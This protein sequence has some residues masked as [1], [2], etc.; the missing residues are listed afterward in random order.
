MSA[1]ADQLR[2]HLAALH[3]AGV[4]FVPPAGPSPELA[5]FAPPPPPPPPPVDTT[6]VAL[7]TLAAEVKKCEKCRELFASRTQTV[8]GGGPVGAVVGFVSD[9]PHADDDRTGVLFA[10]AVG[11]LFDNMLTKGMDL[12]REE[13]YLCAV[14]K[15][16]PPKNRPPKADECN[17]CRGFLERQLALARPQFLCALGVSAAQTLLG[18]TQPLP[19]LRGVV[20]DLGGT[21]LVC[22]HHPAEVQ[23]NPKLKGPVWE[24]LKR[25]LK[26]MGRNPKGK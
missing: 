18:T 5:I 24:D 12:K 6:R 11:E 14:L 2:R 4:R 15:C 16:R 20:H 22:T 3:A 21:P 26:T 13:V 25:L 7:D 9:A 8:I 19:A 23:A 10:G 1:L 17:N